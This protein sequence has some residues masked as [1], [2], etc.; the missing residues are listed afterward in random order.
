VTGFFLGLTW[1]FF[2]LRIYVRTYITGNW[3]LDDIFLIISVVSFGCSLLFGLTLMQIL[4][5]AFCIFGIL[6]VKNGAGKHV[7]NI[8]PKDL[9]KVLIFWYITE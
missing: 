8:L 3:G 1:I 7:S 6:A 2:P 5:T 4:F 9:S